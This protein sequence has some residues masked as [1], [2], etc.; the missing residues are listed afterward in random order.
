MIRRPPRSALFPYTT[1]F[2]SRARSVVGGRQAVGDG[3]SGRRRGGAGLGDGQGNRL[4]GGADLG[5]C[6]RRVVGGGRGAG[7]GAAGV[8]GLACVARRRRRGD[9]KRA[10][11]GP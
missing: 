7:E 10:W 11:A 4:G 2:R 5:G 9:E 1:L 3:A 6:R 8:R